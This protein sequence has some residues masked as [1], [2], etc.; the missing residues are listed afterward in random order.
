[1]M[2]EGNEGQETR[3]N[4][5]SHRITSQG[6]MVAELIPVPAVPAKPPLFLLE[7]LSLMRR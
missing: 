1:M 4:A 5:G 6:R 3:D 2:I 7:Y